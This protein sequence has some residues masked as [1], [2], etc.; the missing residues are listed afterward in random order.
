MGGELVAGAAA[1]HPHLH[2]VAIE[3]DADI[4]LPLSLGDVRVAKARLGTSAVQFWNGLKLQMPAYD[5]RLPGKCA[6]TSRT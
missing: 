4:V 1:G 6:A 5:V 3:D 2:P